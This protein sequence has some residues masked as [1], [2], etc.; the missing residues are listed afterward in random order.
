MNKPTTDAELLDWFLH[1]VRVSGTVTKDARGVSMMSDSLSEF[2]SNIPS[3]VP[4]AE[5]VK[6]PFDYWSFVELVFS[7]FLRASM[8]P[9][10]FSS[11]DYVCVD[12]AP[13]PHYHWSWAVEDCLDAN[14]L[15]PEELRAIHASLPVDP[16]TESHVDTQLALTHAQITTASKQVADH[17]ARIKRGVSKIE[18]S[19][20]SK[21]RNHSL[22]SLL[23]VA[24]SLLKSLQREQLLDSVEE[25]H[26]CGSSVAVVVDDGDR[27]RCWRTSE[28]DI[29]NLL[30][31][32]DA[33]LGA[34]E[35]ESVQ[36][37]YP[38]SAKTGAM[39]RL[40]QMGPYCHICRLPKQNLVNCVGKLSQFYLSTDCVKS[41]CHRKFCLDCLTAY[42]W[43]KPV[44]GT[45]YKCPIC[46]K[47]CTCDRCVRNVFLRVVKQFI[48]GLSGKQV[49]LD[50]QLSE[51]AVYVDSV[52]E[53]FA[54]VGQVPSTPESPD[55]AAPVGRSK[56][57]LSLVTKPEPVEQK[58]RSVRKSTSDPIP[59]EPETS[60]DA[61]L[62]FE[63]DY[64]DAF[65]ELRDQM[66]TAEQNDTDM[67]VSLM[68]S[69][70][71]STDGR[72]KRKS[73]S[74]ATALSRTQNRLI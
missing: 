26:R 63:L 41:T 64:L 48:T 10:Q 74:I 54:I 65:P 50:V 33:L 8:I 68:T 16:S 59:V 32:R 57:T 20:F 53:Y 39:P 19:D 11:E 37:K 4:S 15:R 58:Q 7:P 56:R 22:S 49:A 13:V 29:V 34:S 12:S 44:L 14:S 42:N 23:L 52:H 69:P 71:S 18:K 46:A 51:Q 40:P 5:E 35:T 70:E 28:T 60:E 61:K 30:Q 66:V 9:D 43:P 3:A 31:E 2:F 38:F 55:L 1:K 36:F 6:N 25:L 24:Q 73:A 17:L 67:S 72:K 62:K 45:D 47:L 27:V 21:L